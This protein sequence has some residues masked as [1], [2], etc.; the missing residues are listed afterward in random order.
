[1]HFTFGGEVLSAASNKRSTDS[2]AKEQTFINGLWKTALSALRSL[3]Q[4]EF[5]F[6]LD[7]DSWW[8]GGKPMSRLFWFTE[9]QIDHIKPCYPKV[10]SVGRA[11][12]C[13]VLSG[14]FCVIRNGLQWAD[15]PAEYA[16]TRR[17]TIGSGGGQ[18][19]ACLNASLTNW[20][21]P[22]PKAKGI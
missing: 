20:Q 16:R 3:R 15:A 7:S 18:K 14:I 21:G 8:K 6:P 12:D 2:R 13:K 11:D 17:F 4:T 10:R 22:M 1:V 5:P 9:E 19:T